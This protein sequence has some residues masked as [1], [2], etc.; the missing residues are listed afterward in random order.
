MPDASE[1]RKRSR[2]KADLAVRVRQIGPPRESIEVTTTVDIS[3]N[4]VLFRTRH[5]Y[6]LHG[7]VWMIV[8]YDP[9]AN[10]ANAEFPA[11]IVRIDP[12]PDGSAVVA[13][14][15]HSARSDPAPVNI[16]GRSTLSLHPERRRKDRS[17]LSIPIRVRAEAGTESAKTV[18]ISRTGLLFDTSRSYTVGQ[19][20][21]ITV[22][23]QAETPTEE[24]EARVVRIIERGSIRC[25]ALQYTHTT[26]IRYPES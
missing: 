4:G 19:Q 22:P 17:K 12:L 7:T 1:V 8:P 10:A 18:D 25:I 5:P 21:W 11:T 23:Y 15:F 26:G 24:V 14:R 20:V 9:N 16:Q 2:V 13:V 6:E 3:R